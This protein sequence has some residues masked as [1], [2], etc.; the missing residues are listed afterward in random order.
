[1]DRTRATLYPHNGKIIIF[2][3]VVLFA[4]SNRLVY[5]QKGHSEHFYFSAKAKHTQ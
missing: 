2:M 4:H 3:I 1:M 5:D